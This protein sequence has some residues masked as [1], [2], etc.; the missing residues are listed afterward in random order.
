[1]SMSALH[2]TENQLAE[3][4]HTIDLKPSKNVFL[5]I[6]AAHMGLGG[7][8][9]GPKPMDKYTL[10]AKDI[11]FR[12]TLKPWKPSSGDPGEIATRV[13]PGGSPVE[14]PRDK[15]GVLRASCG[16][17]GSKIMMSIDGSKPIAYTKPIPFR[18]GGVVD[19][20]AVYPKGCIRKKSEKVERAFRRI[21]DRSK[22]KV[23]G[24]DSFQE[25]EGEPEN[26]LDGDTAS[27]WHTQWSGGG[28]K[29]PHEI[30]IS[31]NDTLMIEAL[32]YLPRQDN[33]NGRISAYEIYVSMDGK[34]WG[35]PVAKGEF[36]NSS[37]WQTA[38]FDKPVK[39][40]FVKLKALKGFKNQP[41]A[42][43]AEIDV[44]CAMPK[45]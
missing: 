38:K 9:C 1:M 23:A 14:S 25:N 42:S 8:S 21:V 29:H 27:Y 32:K 3:A 30:A 22:W 39:A 37:A 10:R 34:N 6:D 5:H 35:S 28:P 45:K 20:W 17:P 16:T 36:K 2:V 19:V 11:S 7:A 41:W 12:Y 24:V 15:S 13:P 31:F 26:V 43:T 44:L 18:K 33:G 40:R 4:E